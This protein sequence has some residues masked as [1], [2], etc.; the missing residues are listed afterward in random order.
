MFRLFLIDKVNIPR[1]RIM[2]I[3]NGVDSARF[4]R[5]D[6][7]RLAIDGCPFSRPEHWLVG[8]GGRMQSVKNQVSLAHAFVRALELDPT[9]RTRLRLVMVGDGPIRAVSQAILANA[10]VSELADCRI[11]DRQLHS[12]T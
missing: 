5:G 4:H 1:V 7:G 2:Q 10:G 9:L 8:T 12:L 11:D 3:Y 6:E